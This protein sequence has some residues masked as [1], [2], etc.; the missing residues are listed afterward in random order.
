LFLIFNFVQI[1]LLAE[2]QIIKLINSTAKGAVLALREGRSKVGLSEVSRHK[3]EKKSRLEV[4]TRK[5]P[6]KKE[7]HKISN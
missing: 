6:P 5:T 2:T 4:E 3:I 7:I 1:N